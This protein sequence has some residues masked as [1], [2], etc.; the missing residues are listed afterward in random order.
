MLVDQKGQ[1]H[2]PMEE[3]LHFLPPDREL[4][5]LVFKNGQEPGKEDTTIIPDLEGVFIS[6]GPA[7]LNMSERF[8]SKEIVV[9]RIEAF[10]EKNGLAPMQDSFLMV[11]TSKLAIVDITQELIAQ[12]MQRL[13]EREDVETV[14]KGNALITTEMNHPLLLKP[15][16]CSAIIIQGTA[17]D[18]KAVLGLIHAGRFE[19]NAL[20]PQQVIKHLV[21]KYGCNPAEL[22][23]GIAPGISKRNHTIRE[24]D[25]GDNK[26]FTPENWEGFIEKNE[27][28]QGTIWHLDIRN[29]AIAQMVRMGVDIT[30]I[31]AYGDE[32]DTFVLA[33]HSPPWSFS[34][35]YAQETGNTNGRILVAA[36][37]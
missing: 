11:P 9:P 1:T 29:N 37:L 2:L 4:K 24:I 16:D 18:G 33:A 17:A 32:V 20:F 31:Q 30:R 35:R 25:N 15:A 12:A 27:T 23:I 26:I 19:V 21:E 7:A 6:I 28:A 3:Q 5:R 10:L 8:E 14:I 36:S 34:H 22:I 13:G